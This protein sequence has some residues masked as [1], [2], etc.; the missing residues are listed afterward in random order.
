MA[1]IAPPHS[2]SVQGAY[3]PFELQ[4]SRNQIMGHRSVSIFGFNKDVDT[5]EVTVWPLPSVRPL[6]AAALSMSVSSTSTS[7]LPASTGAHTV[8]IQGLDANYNEISETVTLNGQTA[9]PTTQA[10]I[11]VNYAVVTTA[12]SSNSA[13]G[14]IYIGSGTVTAGV[15]AVV[16]QI[17][18][19]NYNASLTGSYT[20]PAGYTAYVSQGLFSAGQPGGS[21][22]V[23]G[24]LYVIGQNN[25]RTAIA[26][27]TVNNGAAD[28]AFE[29][30]IAVPEKSTL[31]ACAVASS[32]NNE[33]TSLFVLVLIK[34]DC[35]T[36]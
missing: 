7:D 9:V 18:K 25:I 31:E 4:V 2:V 32:N 21:A 1:Q 20:V 33:A 12:G 35:Q 30:P 16:Y 11:R 10:F 15:P 26:I 8:L 6:P 34:N 19:F 13:L 23:E 5:A 36:A 22:Q 17:I 24:K 14:D 29:Y 3:E 28:Y 27:T